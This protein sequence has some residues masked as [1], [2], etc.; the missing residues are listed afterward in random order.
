MIEGIVKAF[1]LISSNLDKIKIEDLTKPK[2]VGYWLLVTI[3]GW[4][5]SHFI[6]EAFPVSEAIG[7]FLG[8]SIVGI[9]QAIVL[10]N[11]F[12]KTW[13]LWIVVTAIGWAI[14]WTQP[15]M[16]EEGFSFPY[17]AITLSFM[18][19]VV[20]YFFFKL[21]LLEAFFWI[22][23]TILAWTLGW[24][25]IVA[26]WSDDILGKI[27]GGF[28]DGIITGITMIILLRKYFGSSSHN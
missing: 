7:G 5:L 18:Q 14:A 27:F 16:F 3:I 6:S 20:L 23:I 12:K 11:F 8:G 13:G 1:E 25:I 17:D 10:K 4:I 19:F 2:F 15:G 21:P 24:N 9:L 22:P 26:N 28:A